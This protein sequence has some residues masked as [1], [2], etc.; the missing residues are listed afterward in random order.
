MV[1]HPKNEHINIFLAS[2]LSVSFLIFFSIVHPSRSIKRSHVS[3]DVTNIK[4]Q[5]A[6]SIYNK[7]VFNDV[8]I[9]GRAYVV[10]DL[11]THEVIASK[12]A[13]TTLPLASLTKV[14]TAVSATRH[15][16]RDEKITILQKN[17]DGKY[18]L[19]LKNHQV[20]SLGE[21]L[22]Y[23]LMFSSNDGA[24]TIADSFGSIKIFIDQMNNDAN[25]LG[26]HFLFTDPAGLDVD[27]QIGG[28]GNALDVAKLFGIARTQIPDLLD[29]TTKKRQSVIASSGKISGVP[30]TNQE[31]EDLP[32]AE[33]SKTGYTDM[34]GGNLGIVVDVSLGHPVAIIVLGS[35]RDGR[36]KD[37]S[38]LYQTLLKS[39]SNN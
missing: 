28:L 19:G 4:V 33:A 38:I 9:E 36:F 29:A 37:V 13:S 18:D 11:R 27:G 24:R 25:D 30:N 15:K 14:M 5:S 35:S 22:K 39:L 20:W 23:T 3:Q 21:L 7:N 31:I 1:Y 16:A 32:G 12:N 6:L 8:Q 34:A 17:I 10:Y 2:V 26:L